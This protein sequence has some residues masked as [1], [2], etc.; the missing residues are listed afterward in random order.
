[1][2]HS[3]QIKA[4]ALTIA[5]IGEDDSAA[6]ETLTKDILDLAAQRMEDELGPTEWTTYVDLIQNTTYDP[7]V[8]YYTYTDDQKKL[9]TLEKAES[10]FALFYLVPALKL[11]AKGNVLEDKFSTGSA[12]SARDVLPSDMQEIFRSQAMYERSALQL[13]DGISTSYSTT[14]MVV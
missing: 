11:I 9:N 14:I 1:M 12:G 8:E 4:R 5:N 3:D 6:Y 2:A 7:T 13:I 10:F